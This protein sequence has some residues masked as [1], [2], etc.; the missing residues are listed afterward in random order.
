MVA[1]EAST[2]HWSFLR[3]STTSG[4][5]KER[6]VEDTQRIW[7]SSVIVGPSSGFCY[8]MILSHDF[9]RLLSKRRR[10]VWQ[11][12]IHFTIMHILL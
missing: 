12:L 5:A 1:K 9:W 3:V 8:L 7:W 11:R 6:L 10:G 2:S 4:L